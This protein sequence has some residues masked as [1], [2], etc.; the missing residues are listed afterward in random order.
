MLCG[1]NGQLTQTIIQQEK[2]LS[3]TQ[4]VFKV[5]SLFYLGVMLHA[6]SLGT[7]AGVVV[8]SAIAVATIPLTVG[9]VVFDL[10]VDDDEEEDNE[11]EDDS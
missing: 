10:M 6:C 5:S 8:D 11:D 4:K 2:T 7:A 9:G 1:A 3:I